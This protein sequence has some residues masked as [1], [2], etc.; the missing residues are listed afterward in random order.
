MS[1]STR[2]E[3]RSSAALLLLSSVA[4]IAVAIVILGIAS[5]GARRSP[6]VA[7]TASHF[8]DLPQASAAP[9]RR[10]LVVADRGEALPFMS[11][12]S[13]LLMASLER[14]KLPNQPVRA[15]VQS[16]AN[17]QPDQ[18]G[19][20]HCLNELDIGGNT[21]VVR[22]H[23]KMSEVPCLTPGEVVDVLALKQYHG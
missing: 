20:S 17:C 12:A 21:V 23:H 22:H 14:G 4:L 3:S 19:V 11:G 9:A 15:T 2:P 5:A 13:G 6:A 18:D 16:D 10:T 1:R 8:V 7:P